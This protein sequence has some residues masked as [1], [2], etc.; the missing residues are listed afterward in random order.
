[1]AVLRGAARAPP[2]ETLAKVALLEVEAL[3][4]DEESLT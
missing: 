4:E 3:A 2:D 1:M